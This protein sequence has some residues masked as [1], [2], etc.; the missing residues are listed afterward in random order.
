MSETSSNSDESQALTAPDQTVL[1]IDDVPY[2]LELATLF[3]ARTARVLTATS[4]QE[5]LDSIARNRP[6][7]ILCDDN[8]PNMNGAQVCRKVR[9]DPELQAMPF[10]ML[11]SD[12]GAAARGAAIRAGADDVISKPLSRVSLVEGVSRFLIEN[13]VRGLPRVDTN[14]PVTV[15]T[16]DRELSGIVRNLSRGGA[17]IETEIPLVRSDEVGL[18]LELSDPQVTL[19]ASAEVVWC[20]TRYE[21]VDTIDGA[22][23]R[24][25][26]IDG[27][28]ARTI[29]DFV[30]ERTPSAA[31]TAG[32]GS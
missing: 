30:Y 15:T 1:I 29:D 6:D 10:I 26:E 7:L 31:L 17:F 27:A 28:S 11:L 32:A 21:S 19:S 12:P 24:F 20:R 13:R 3:L 8:M 14:V 18:R 2:L 25:V 16:G 9:Q 22:G 4:G 5:G 23:L